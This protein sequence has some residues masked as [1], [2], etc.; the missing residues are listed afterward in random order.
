MPEASQAAL[1]TSA[2]MVE[3]GSGVFTL[4][5][6]S[7]KTPFVIVLYP[8]CELE[9]CESAANAK[10]PEIRLLAQ[11]SLV[12][13]SW[14]S[15]LEIEVQVVVAPFFVSISQPVTARYEK[16]SNLPGFSTFTELTA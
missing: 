3:V 11:S 13:A 7:V 6:T 10:V 16:A 8:D 4:I 2:V 5:G 1:F 9:A 15:L 12:I 14:Q